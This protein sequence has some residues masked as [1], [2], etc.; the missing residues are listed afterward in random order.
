RSAET[1]QCWLEGHKEKI[2]MAQKLDTELDT[3]RWQIEHLG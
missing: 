3:Y 2:E 1:S